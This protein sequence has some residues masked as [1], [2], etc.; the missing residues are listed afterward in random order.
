MTSSDVPIWQAWSQTWFPKYEAVFSAMLKYL[1]QCSIT[2]LEDAVENL[3]L[4]HALIT[5]HEFF[6]AD[7]LTAV[8]NLLAKSEEMRGAEEPVAFRVLHPVARPCLL[9]KKSLV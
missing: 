2:D 7:G 5:A 4:D 6:K 8:E 3:D 9:Q 1:Y